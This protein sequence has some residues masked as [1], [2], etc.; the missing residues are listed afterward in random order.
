MADNYWT[1]TVRNRY[2]RRTALRTGGLATAGLAGLALVGCGDDDDDGGDSGDPTVSI[3]QPTTDTS[4]QPK[5]GGLYRWAWQGTP[6]LDIHQDSAAGALAIIT[7]TYNR[8]MRF[9]DEAQLPEPDLAAKMPEQP[10]PTTIVFTIREGV[11]FH[12]KPP[13]NGR[14]MTAED[15]AF[16]LNRARTDQPSFIHKGDLVSIDKVEA[17]D[18]KTVRIT[19][20][21]PNAVLLTTLAGAQFIVLAPETVATYGDLKTDRATIGTGAFVVDSASTDQGAQLSRHPNY[22]RTG[23]PYLDKVQQFV[24]GDHWSQFLAGN[25]EIV[26]IAAEIQEG[27]D[28][29][30]EVLKDAGVDAY[31]IKGIG[32]GSSQGHFM[33]NGAPPFND[34]KVRQAIN[35]ILDRDPQLTYGYPIG[36]YRM[37]AL[38]DGHVSAGWGLTEKEV[39]ALPGYRTDKAKRDQDIKDAL[40]LFAAAGYTKD[41]P[42]KWEIMGWAV[43]H[44]TIGIDE[45]Q[46]ACEMYKQVSGGVLDPTPKG[47]EWGTWK[48]AEANHEFQMISSAYLMGNDAHEALQKM[49]SSTGGRN[50]AQFKDP[51]FDEMLIKEQGTFDLE[52]RKKLVKEMVQYIND[53]VRIANAWTGTGPTYSAVTSKLRGFPG[54]WDSGKVDQI[55]FA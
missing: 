31:A 34:I 17:V 20:K 2:S 8:V 12:N 16:S 22:F 28:T 29:T 54:L 26:T 42:L 44:R 32:G 37:V 49:Y 30:E 14:V 50:F 21:F 43:P 7:A 41:N 11:K 18:A 36:G 15:V 45:L 25:L 35:L 40:A 24:I 27:F 3:A 9:Q 6:H 38:G 33:N 13:V 47:L 4:A 23:K 1:R 10:D 48:A 53:P 55:W 39:L 19:T 52:Q 51:K 46:L 5:R